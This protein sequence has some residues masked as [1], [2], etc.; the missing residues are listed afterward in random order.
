M[1]RAGVGNLQ[2]CHANMRSHGPSGMDCRFIKPDTIALTQSDKF[3]VM[4]Q[5]GPFRLFSVDG[6]HTV[7]HTFSCISWNSIL[8][9][10]LG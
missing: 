3:K 5:R 1:A 9:K 6:C 4:Q 2:H 10:A 7:E 8:Q